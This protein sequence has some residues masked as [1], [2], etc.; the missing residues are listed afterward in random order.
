MTLVMSADKAKQLGLQPMGIFRHFVVAGC[1]P[2]VVMVGCG[3]IPTREALAAV[4]TARAAGHRVM[5]TRASDLRADPDVG[6][7]LAD[8]ADGDDPPPLVLAGDAFADVDPEAV[9]AHAAVTMT[10]VELPGGGQLVFDPDAEFPRRYVGL[11]G[12]P[13][14]PALGVLGEQPVPASVERAQQVADDY[15][16]VVDDDV[17]IIPS[18]EIIATVASSSAGDDGDY[19]NELPISDLRP[20]VDAAGDAGLYVLLDLQPGR[21]D[22]MTQAKRY[23]ELLRE[24]H[25][26]LALDPEWRLRPDEKHLAQIGSVGIDEVNAVAD[27]LAELTRPN[28]LPQKMLLLHQFRLSMIRERARLDTSHPELAYVVQMDGQG[29]QHT[30]LETWA[31]VTANAPTRVQFGWKNFYDED[32]PLRSPEATMALEPPPVFVS[33]Q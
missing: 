18:F 28:R 26:G 4:V 21:T 6:A 15:R 23:R 20:A 13:Q 12:V 10:G 32:T 2:D 1:E 5:A 14:S 11:Y 27:W 7:R 29:P 8:L 25:V 16:A 24:P 17:T 30:K 22:F 31:A 19:S 3:G 33:Y 9:V